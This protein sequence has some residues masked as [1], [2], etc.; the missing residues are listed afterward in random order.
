MPQAA[1]KA[2][3]NTDVDSMFTKRMGGDQTPDSSALPLTL[4]IDRGSHKEVDGREQEGFRAVYSTPPHLFPP[5][6]FGICGTLWHIYG[7]Q[8]QL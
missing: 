5:T 3:I 7:K 8:T 1:V 6:F 2:L 4:I